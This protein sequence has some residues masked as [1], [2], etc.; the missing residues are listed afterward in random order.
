MALYQLE[1]SDINADIRVD[2]CTADNLQVIR[3]T[4]WWKD[5]VVRALGERGQHD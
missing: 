4:V 5:S 2:I 1:L 3:R